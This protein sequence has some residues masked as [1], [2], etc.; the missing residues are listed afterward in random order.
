MRLQYVGI[1]V[2]NLARSIRFYT[3]VL[4]L[5]EYIRGDFRKYGRGIWVGLTDPRTGAKLEL[6]WY[7]RGSR[8]AVPGELGIALD[9]IGFEVPKRAMVRTYRRLLAK[10]ARPTEVTPETTEGWG[11]Y[12]LDPDGNWIELYA[13]PSEPHRTRTRRR[14]KGCAR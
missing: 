2:R 4:G 13:P 9:H 8:Y 11:A 14:S 3:E 1:R 6:N 7:P 12:L 5:R 10:G